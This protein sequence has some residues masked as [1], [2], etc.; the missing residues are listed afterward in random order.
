M[1]AARGSDVVIAPPDFYVV[2]DDPLAVFVDK[3]AVILGIVF[4]LIA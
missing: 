1:Y 4:D 2:A 3:M